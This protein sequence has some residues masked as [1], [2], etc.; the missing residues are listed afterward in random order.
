MLA[1]AF[2]L[3]CQLL[4][5]GQQETDTDQWEAFG[6]PGLQEIQRDAGLE[7]EDRAWIIQL[8][9]V[10]VFV[11]FF[12]F[13]FSFIFISWRLTTLQHCSGFCHTLA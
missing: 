4:E 2:Q 6:G 12:Y 11:L 13:Y 1:D 10:F 5:L 3:S 9:F 7:A 8:V